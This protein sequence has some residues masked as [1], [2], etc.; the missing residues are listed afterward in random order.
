MK[1]FNAATVIVKIALIH[2]FKWKAV[3]HHCN[4]IE[5]TRLLTCSS[6]TCDLYVVTHFLFWEET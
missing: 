2:C 5:S 6:L 1:K 3:S 4:K